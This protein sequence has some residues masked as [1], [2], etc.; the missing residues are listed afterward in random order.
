MPAGP[1]KAAGH[2][3]GRPRHR[4]A[5]RHFTR[6]RPPSAAPWGRNGPSRPVPM[7]KRRQRPGLVAGIRLH[8]GRGEVETLPLAGHWTGNFTTTSPLAGV[9]SP[10]WCQ[11]AWRGHA[12]ISKLTHRLA[13]KCGKKSGNF[14]GNTGKPAAIS[15]IVV[16]GHAALAT[17]RRQHWRGMTRPPRDWQAPR[18]YL[19][20][21]MDAKWAKN[22][23]K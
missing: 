3:P 21:S 6:Q 23:D 9:D 13:A 17:G 7:L 1:P 16:G 19:H 15:L 12:G 10:L 14:I 2:A 8:G 20:A 18:D 11:A 5:H 4:S 22:W